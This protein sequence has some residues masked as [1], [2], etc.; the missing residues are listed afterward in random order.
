MEVQT[1]TKV[2]ASD[3]CRE[4]L[5]RISEAALFLGICRSKM[6]ALLADGTIPYVRVGADRRIPKVALVRY[7]QDRLVQREPAR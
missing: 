5:F 7:A 2:G 6:D 4:G 1:K 3:L